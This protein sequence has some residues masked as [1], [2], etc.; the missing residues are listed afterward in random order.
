L[1][2]GEGTA[3]CREMFAGLRG[4]ALAALATQLDAAL[5]RLTAVERKV[6]G[7]IED[8]VTTRNEIFQ[9]FDNHDAQVRELHSQNQR[10]ASETLTAIGT[11]QGSTNTFNELLPALKAG[12]QE[13]AKRAYTRKLASRVIATIVSTIIFISALIPLAQL[14]LGLHLTFHFT[15]GVY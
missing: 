8:C 11:L 13:D 5:D 3:R 7:H 6:D 10:T 15:G 4:V 12:I 1:G 14:L 9:R 2:L